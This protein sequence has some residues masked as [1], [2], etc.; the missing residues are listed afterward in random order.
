MPKVFDCVVCNLQLR[1]ILVLA[2]RCDLL[3]FE[4]VGTCECCRTAG[5]SRCGC[6]DGLEVANLDQFGSDCDLETQNSNSI[7][8][9][10]EMGL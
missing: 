4:L 7:N 10:N 9:I 8:W 3:K 6:T 1:L 5:R 2:R